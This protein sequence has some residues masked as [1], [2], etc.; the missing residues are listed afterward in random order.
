MKE[1]WI[2]NS[3]DRIALEE[4][5]IKSSIKITFSI[6]KNVVIKILKESPV[7]KIYRIHYININGKNE[8]KDMEFIRYQ[9]TEKPI[10][11]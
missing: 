6:L 7:Q 3:S 8:Y 9:F 11:L 5:C 1:I 4:S 2:S 10:H